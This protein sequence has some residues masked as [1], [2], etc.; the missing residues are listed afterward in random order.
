[1]SPVPR[2]SWDYV[3][4]FDSPY[5]SS[6]SS[7]AS[8]SPE[9]SVCKEAKKRLSERW[10]MMTYNGSCQERRCV[11]R[12][13][14]TLGEMLAL[15]ETKNA[16]KPEEEVIT[17]EDPKDSNP[18][19]I[20]DQKKVEFRDSSPTNLLRSKYVPASSTEFSRR[21]DVKISDLDES[22]SDVRKQAT[23][24][25]NV[26]SSLKGKV[27]T[28]DRTECLSDKEQE[29]HSPGLL[30]LSS[31]SSSTNLIGKRGLISPEVGL[32]VTKSITSGNSSENQ[33]Q[34]SPISVLD[35]PF[36]EDEHTAPESSGDSKLDRQDIEF[37]I[38]LIEKSP[39]IGSIARTLSWDDSCMDTASSYPLTPSL[40]AQGAKEDEREWFFLVRTLLSVAGLDGEVEYESFL[41]RWNSSESPLDPSLR[42]KYMDLKDKEIPHEAKRIQKISTQKLVFDCVNAAL[43]DIAGYGS[44]SCQ[45]AIP[46]TGA[47]NS[48]IENASFTMVNQMWAIM[49]TWFSGE[50]SYV[51][52]DCG[53]DDS[54]VVEKV[55]R[56]EVVGKRWLD[57][58]RM[59][60]VKL[61]KEIETK[62]LDEL[63]QEAVAE[64]REH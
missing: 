51:L 20:N 31:K 26:K 35:A 42:D 41:A 28:N 40:P 48:L 37:S 6:S 10:A 44:D 50:V 54:Q 57:H 33:D 2:Q 7:H 12:S 39:P 64:L 22:K 43:V 59:E 5:S 21:L 46:C 52:G 49:K 3:N 11:R 25:R 29:L 14:S 56:N 8:Y 32:S 45:R 19:F 53:N 1:M 47:N 18:L 36:E 9:S 24:V 62:L 16:G 17:I 30:E 34:Q 61:G 15:S 63:V 23:K 13:S 27:S 55:V 38:Q 4:R 58:F 60:T